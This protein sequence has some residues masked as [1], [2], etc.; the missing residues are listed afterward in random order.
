MIKAVAFDLDGVLIDSKEL[1]YEALNTALRV[2]AGP[3]Y[4]IS[5]EEHLR[6]FDGLA[7]TKKLNLLKARKGLS[8]K[9]FRKIWFRKQLET[10]KKLSSLKRR[11]SIEKIFKYLQKKKIKIFIATNATRKTALMA[12]RRLRLLAYVSQVY[13]NEDI[14]N[15]K[16]HPEI[17]LRCM[18]AAACRPE[19][20]LV[21]EDSPYGIQSAAGSGAEYIVVKSVN[22]LTLKK[23]RKKIGQE[24]KTRNLKRNIHMG[25]INVLIPMAGEGRRFAEAGY[26]FPKPLIEVPNQ[27]GKTMIQVVI[28]SLGI[29]GKKIFVVQSGHRKSY[30][31]DTFLT[32]LAP[33]CQLF[34]VEKITDGAACTCLL[35]KEAINNDD[36]LVIA[37][38]DQFLDWKPEEFVY[39]MRNKKADFGILTF[40]S[41]HPKWSYAKTSSSGL[42]IEVAE[43]KVISNQATVGVYYWKQ[44]RD[45]VRSAERMIKKNIRVGQ[46]FN[47]KG[48]F[49]VCPTFNELIAEG[50]NG[51]IFKIKKEQMYGLGTP[52]DL[53][54]FVDHGPISQ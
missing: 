27:S 20:L 24:L 15:Q 33:G 29:A 25:D 50:A 44:G 4:C 32:A 23:I 43:K 49:Y 5:M 10:Y 46:S 47:G 12:A 36:E 54:Y 48:E 18:V 40:N 31:L 11:E 14:Q 35:A 6:F 30:N 52:E 34:S 1:H 21:V 26:S 17:Y 9:L 16:P 19:E 28:D 42:I 13:G 38:S 53:K 45:F 2:V 8:E 39:F 41:N 37:N 3:S 51:Y 7:T 22:D